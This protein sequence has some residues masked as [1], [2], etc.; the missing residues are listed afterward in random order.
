MTQ[1]ATEWLLDSDPAIRWQAMRALT[2]APAADIAAERAKV[3]QIG[4]GAVLLGRQDTDG[5]WRT[6]DYDIASGQWVGSPAWTSMS[7]LQL[8]RE[9]GVDPADP[10]VSAAIARLAN[11]AGFLSS[12]PPFMPWAGHPFFVGET[13]P[14]I[15]GRVVAAGAY[16]GQNV[17]LLVDRLLGEQMADG[18]WNCEQENGSTRGSFGTTI[19][20][21]EGLLEFERATGG[22]TATKDARKRGEEYVLVRGLVRRLS[23]GEPIKPDF[24]RFAFPYGWRYDIL[25]GLDYFRA[26]GAPH[27]P[28]MDEALALVAGKRGADGRWPLEKA[29]ADEWVLDM[30]EAEGQP[31]RWITLRAMR[32][33]AYFSAA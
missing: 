8:L 4:W 11:S 26:A 20:V 19:N 12:M 32:V 28:R 25:R 18:G 30:G 33:L 9:F 1:E 16:F 13:E 29:Y 10:T 15:N 27:D 2:D 3:T 22:T 23:T 17:E 14:C 24:A 6:P 31:S 21:L 5:V 7:V